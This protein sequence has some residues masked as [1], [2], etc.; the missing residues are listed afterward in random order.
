MIELS[1]E[2]LIVKVTQNGNEVSL[3]FEFPNLQHASEVFHQ[4]N[5]QASAGKIEFELSMGEPQ[6]IGESVGNA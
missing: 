5:T 1:G 2:N 4:L 3:S 6:F